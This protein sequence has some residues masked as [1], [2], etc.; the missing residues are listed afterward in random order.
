MLAAAGDEAR[1]AVLA[2]DISLGAE[3]AADRVLADL[4]VRTV[5][6]EAAHM[7]AVEEIEIA[8]FARRSGEVRHRPFLVRQRHDATRAEILIGLVEGVA[9]RR[10]EIFRDVTQIGRDRGGAFAHLPLAGRRTGRAEDAVTGDDIESPHLIDRW[11]G[12]R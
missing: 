11:R 4:L 10:R 12:A 3:A 1:G 2:D 9:V 5:R 6:R 8:V 7:V